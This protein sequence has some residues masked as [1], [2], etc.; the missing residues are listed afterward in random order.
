M[1]LPI[2]NKVTVQPWALDLY[3]CDAVLKKEEAICIRL[4]EIYKT[5]N[6]NPKKIKSLINKLIEEI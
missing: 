2:L 1:K 5:P 4:L 6:K 3:R